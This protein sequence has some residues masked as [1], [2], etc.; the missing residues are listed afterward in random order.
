MAIVSD[1]LTALGA[2]LNPAAAQLLQRQQELA[3]DR[4]EK[5]KRNSKVQEQLQTLIGSPQSPFIADTF[6]GEA[7]LQ[8]LETAGTGFAANMTPEQAQQVSQLAE[9]APETVLKQ[10]AGQAFPSSGQGGFTLSPGQSRF[11][12]QGNV[13]ANSA[14]N[15]SQATQPRVQSSKQLSGGLVQLVMTDGTVKTVPTNEADGELIKSAE[16]RGAELQGLREGFRGEAKSSTKLAL[17]AY[18]GITS[19]RKQIRDLNEGIKLLESGAKTGAVQS[20]L[21]S[22]R[23]ESI[24]LDN[25]QKRLGLNVISNTTFGALS[26]GELDL[27]MSTSLPKRLNEKELIQWMTEKRDAQAKLLDYF[28]ETAEFLGTPGNTVSDFLKLQKNK[29]AE[30]EQVLQDLAQPKSVPVQPTINEL[31]NKYAN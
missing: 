20:L 15:Q 22:I 19:G 29:T 21:P 10:I 27:A 31:V 18:K 4:D 30:P 1:F 25:L 17:S 13:I 7:P 23:A 28:Q 12:A 2:G 14:V 26:Q 9:I 16:Q 5:L 6:P 24:K 8:G 11:D 3:F